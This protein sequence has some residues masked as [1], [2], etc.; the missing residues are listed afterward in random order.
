MAISRVLGSIVLAAG[1]LALAQGC[2][3]A[4]APDQ[5][6]SINP[7]D[8]GTISLD[9]VNAPADATCLRLTVK[10]TTVAVRSFTLKTTQNTTLMASGLPTGQVLVT[11]EAFGTA[12]SQL[13]TESVATYV[14]D[15]APPVTLVPG[16]TASIAITLQKASSANISVDFPNVG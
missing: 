16:Q 11:G 5:Q 2:E 15:A 13:T 1:A 9:L 4:A 3:S 6:A 10:G 14:S 7:E 12:C 8:T